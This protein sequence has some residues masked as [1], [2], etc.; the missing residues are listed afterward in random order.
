MGTRRNFRRGWVVQ[1]VKY[2]P[3]LASPGIAWAALVKG[4]SAYSTKAELLP[5]ALG[6]LQGWPSGLGC[7]DGW[8]HGWSAWAVASSGASAGRRCHAVIF[9]ALLSLLPSPLSLS[10]SSASWVQAV[11]LALVFGWALALHGR[12]CSRFP[13]LGRAGAPLLALH[14]L[15]LCWVLALPCV[16]WR[17]ALP[18]LLLAFAGR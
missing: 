9:C 17:L 14:P 16:L 5:L 18:W 3:C 6:T 2:P 10:R 11:G 12:R 1:N 15:R 7:W 8:R 13:G 4:G